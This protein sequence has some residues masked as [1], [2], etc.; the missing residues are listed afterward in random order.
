MG[1]CVVPSVA[2]PYPNPDPDPPDQHVFGP[3]ESRSGTISQRY[4]S[5]SSYNQAKIVRKILI[6]TALRLLFDFLSLK[7]MKM[8]LQKAEVGSAILLGGALSLEC[9]IFFYIC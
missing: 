1:G 2:D 3:P 6:P 9:Y 4:G 7:M 5:R 8:Y